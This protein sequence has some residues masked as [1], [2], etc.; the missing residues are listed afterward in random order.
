MA[1][2]MK[3]I[4]GDSKVPYLVV[5]ASISTG[6]AVAC[7]STDDAHPPY[8][9]CPVDAGQ[10]RDGGPDAAAIE[11]NCG[12]PPLPPPGQAGTGGQNGQGTGG[13]PGLGGTS[14]G[15]TAPNGGAQP[16]TGGVPGSG[17][18]GLGGTGSGGFGT[19]NAFTGGVGNGGVNNTGGLGVG[20][21]LGTGADFGVG[22][23][24]L[25]PGNGGIPSFGGSS[26]TPPTPGFGGS[27]F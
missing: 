26:P 12:L 4:F 17:G 19:G 6:V 8:L 2:F 16:V 25:P 9:G 18:L 21:T 22:G 14:N 1:S 23:S 13:V 10:P 15:G 24:V 5:A 11:L 7:H 3:R 20:A 27:A